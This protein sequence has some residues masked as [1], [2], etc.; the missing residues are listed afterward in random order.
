[1][2]RPAAAT[3]RAKAAS[4]GL[5]LVVLPLS[6]AAAEVERGAVAAAGATPRVE[7]APA[8]SPIPAP[9]A[10]ARPA[11]AAARTMLIARVL[12]NTVP[13]GDVPLVRDEHGRMLVPL[14]EFGGWGLAPGDKA[15]VHG[16]DGPWI[17]L[18]VVPG[19]DARFD[20]ATVTLRVNVVASALPDTML[21]LGPARHRGVIFP[22]ERSFF[23]NYGFDATGDERFGERRYLLATEAG[24]RSG[25][26]LLYNTTSQQ[27]GSG[28]PAGFV[29]LQTRAEYDD[30]ANLRRYALGDFVTPAAD[31]HAAVP[32]GGVSLT[33]LYAMDPYY[34]R[35]PTA[36]FA[37]ELALPSTVEVR[38]DGNLI[39]QRQVP[40]GPLRI[41]NVTTGLTGAQNVSVVVRDPFGRE[42]VLQQPFFFATN[43]GLAAG[44]HEYSYNAGFVRRR[45]GVRSDDYG[46]FGASL[47]HRYAFTDRLT[48]GVRGQASASLWNAGPFG[49]WQSPLG[50]VGVGV[51]IGGRD[52]ASAAAGTA[53]Y[54]YTGSNASVTLGALYRGR[55]YGELADL[56]GNPRVRSNAYASGS[57]YHPAWGTLTATY[58]ALTS[59][60]GLDA[61]VTNVT[62][63]RGLLG[64]RGLLSL[65]YLRSGEPQSS[66]RWLLSFRYF[67]DVVTSVVASAGYA[68]GGGTQA[69]AVQRSVPQGE[70]V[71]YEV[72]VGHVGADGSDAMTGR[73]FVQVNAAHAALGGEYA[74]A[75][76]GDGSSGVGRLFVAGSV[77]G[78]GGRLFAA[79]PVQD[80]FALVRVAG[81]ADIPVYANGWFAGRT[82][83]SGEVVATNLASYYDNTLSFGAKDLPLDYVFPI[84]EVVISPPARS[85]TLVEFAVRRYRAIVGTLV[86]PRDGPPIA[87]EF[88]EITLQRGDATLRS[89]TARRGEFYVEGVE[90]GDYVLR[91]TNGTTCSARVAIPELV[92]A[93]TDIGA[94]ACVPAPVPGR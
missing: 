75:G 69:L 28:A 55:D 68:D 72:G 22:A 21:D 78:V 79:R 38:V 88:R 62:W 29:R 18:T 5:L 9:A 33:K 81:L 77:G 6:L 74:R 10:S 26:W 7:T 45:Y 27:W 90:P 15:V 65:G 35:Y 76:R 3:R 70:G 67:F 80:S 63:T 31:L 66:Q 49:T 12:L 57:L 58:S 52:G 40:P 20:A 92:A 59:Y 43:A 71:G 2:W 93:I 4:A 47:A 83:A 11:P 17:D 41:A 32:M 34:V 42:Q 50:I 53:A 56:T 1:M 51:G 64:G 30:R 91:A 24:A 60:E 19:L 61:K 37:S 82:D 39:A 54:S 84:S 89:F 86:E 25:N 85:G 13:R 87:L 36:A 73:A 94:I 23:V 44:L 14:G 16:D 46:D 8:A 48:L